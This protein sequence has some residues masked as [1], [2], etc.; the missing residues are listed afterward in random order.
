MKV[1]VV[2]N[3][4][5]SNVYNM[6]KTIKSIFSEFH[7]DE[8]CQIFFNDLDD[9]DT[10]SCDNYFIIRDKDV[11]RSVQK[12]WTRAGNI[13]ECC[14]CD[15]RINKSDKK[16]HRIKRNSFT[17]ILREIV[18]S[19]GRLNYNELFKWIRVQDPDVIFFV[20][21]YA[22][23]A[24]RLVEKIHREFNIPVAVYFTDDYVIYP[25]RTLYRRYLIKVYK[26]TLEYASQYF[27]IGKQMAQEYTD[28]FGKRFISIMNIVDYQD[29]IP[30]RR[31]FVIN[32][33]YFGSLYYNR[34]ES[35][36]N[37]AR[38]LDDY[39]KPHLKNKY[40]IN[41][42]SSSELTR[43]QRIQFDHYNIEYR[44]FVKG[45]DFTEAMHVADIYLHIESES[46][47]YRALTHLCVST[48]IPE[49]LMSYRPSIAFGPAEVASMKLY[50]EIDSRMVIPTEMDDMTRLLAI[51]NIANI[52][53]DYSMRE[54]IAEKCY[55]YACENFR[56]DVVSK[57]FK[58]NIAMTIKE[59]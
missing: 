34:C 30:M 54:E 17:Q 46:E 31:S 11:L 12:P 45:A 59:F 9:L 28:F 7:K 16:S 40:T 3:N 52:I 51:K 20:G 47:E 14:Q 22:I 38:L 35:I 25:K 29:R 44:G 36:I 32:I 27:A 56:K 43:E 58:R 24:H 19:L 53:N 42:F 39:V 8:V 2:S 26:R 33:S 37:F 5:F 50:E 13:Y 1:L 6:G 48:K 18:W 41:V 57:E 55:N 49:Y 23:F 4:S 10:D 21:G 15:C